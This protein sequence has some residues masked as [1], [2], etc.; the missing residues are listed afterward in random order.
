ML[1][2]HSYTVLQVDLCVSI[3]VL[4]NYACYGRPCYHHLIHLKRLFIATCSSVSEPCADVDRY[5]ESPSTLITLVVVDFKKYSWLMR[6]YGEFTDSLISAKMHIHNMI[7]SVV[8]MSSI[9][10]AAAHLSVLE[11]TRNSLL[12]TAHTHN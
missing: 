5:I 9:S 7:Y 1:M 12:E 10:C 8:H 11:G 2:D 6:L 3:C 4:Q